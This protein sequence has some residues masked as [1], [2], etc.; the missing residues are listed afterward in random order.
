M[1]WSR[2][3]LDIL[4]SQ[5]FGAQLPTEAAG[6]RRTY[7]RVTHS[8]VHSKCSYR[9]ENSVFSWSD[10][11]QTLGELSYYSTLG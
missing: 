1:Q 6:R 8:P 2:E 11:R 5:W 3:T 7:S 4:R 10:S 9:S